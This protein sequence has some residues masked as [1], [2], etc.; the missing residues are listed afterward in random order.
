MNQKIL[1]YDKL[2]Y[3]ISFVLKDQSGFTICGSRNG[4]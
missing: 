2:S 3:G 1:F 4:L